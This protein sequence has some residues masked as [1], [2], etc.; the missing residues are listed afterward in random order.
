MSLDLILVAASLFLYGIGEGLFFYFQPLY[1]E[2]LG[3]DPVQIG[4][5]LSLYGLMMA[6]A[7]VPA[8][9]LADRFGRRP[10]IWAAWIQGALAAWIMYLAPGQSLFITGMLLYAM[11]YYVMSPM[12]SYITIARGR[13]PV[14]RAIL[15]CSSAFN[16]GMVIGPLS[17]G[18]LGERYG[19]RQVYLLAAFI[20]M[21][22]TVVILFIRRQPVE[23]RPGEQG[24]FGFLANPRHQ[25]Y[26]LVVLLAAFATYLPIPFSQNFLNGQRGLNLE[27]IGWLTALTGIGV[28]VLS[29]GLSYLKDR[30]SFLLA[31]LAVG[32]FAW[33]LWRETSLPAYA[34][35]YFLLGGY[36]TV[37]S[38][39]VA[40]TRE[41]VH[42]SNMGLAY[43]V[44][45]M[46][47]SLASM[48]APLLA[49]VV[50]AYQP[51]WIFPFTILAILISA[52]V[53]LRFVPRI[54]EAIAGPVIQN[55]PIFV[56][57]E[58]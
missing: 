11:T 9:Y 49:G 34:L 25:A 12:N 7:Q 39:A 53:S 37:R 19:L 45:E 4:V 23:K 16:L 29:I 41:L 5:V 36:K 26:L 58:V 42:T 13:W 47:G 15:M 8:G 17:G 44:T 1:L 18:I 50:Y 27:T 40:Q 52:A 3:A 14:G 30:H 33:L 35:G 51:V 10:L 48:A 54:S 31:Q 56:Q 43:G 6:V 32:L 2:Q 20:F 21:A 46:T 38:L 28:A 57:E 24:G 55:E 22:A